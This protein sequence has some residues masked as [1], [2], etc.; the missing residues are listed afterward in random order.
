MSSKQEEITKQQE[1]ILKKQKAR[2]TTAM[3][4]ERKNEIKQGR[5][6]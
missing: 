4:D 3:N 1:A 6:K 5:K 2:N